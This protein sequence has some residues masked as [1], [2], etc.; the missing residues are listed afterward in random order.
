[1]NDLGEEILLKGKK[2]TLKMLNS[3]PDFAYLTKGVWTTDRHI[4]SLV[5]ELIHNYKIK[6]NDLQGVYVVRN[7]QFLLVM[8]YQQEF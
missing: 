5:A 3:V 8:S 1:M 2:F 7:L 6:V 4:N